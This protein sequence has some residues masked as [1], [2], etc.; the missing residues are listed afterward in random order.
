MGLEARRIRSALPSKQINWQFI[1]TRRYIVLQN[2]YYNFD[3][4]ICVCLIN[5]YLN[6]YWLVVATRN[7]DDDY[8]FLVEINNSF[9]QINYAQ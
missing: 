2:F 9:I 1:S 4:C 7:C 5:Y 8:L 6:V 3:G